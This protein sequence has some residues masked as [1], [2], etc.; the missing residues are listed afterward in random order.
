MPTASVIIAAGGLGR[1]FLAAGARAAERGPF[2]QH[3]TKA[4]VPLAGKPVLAHTLACFAEIPSVVEFIVAVPEG[5]LDWA[6][7]HFDAAGVG[8]RR[9]KIVEGGRDRPDSVAR[10]LEVSDPGTELVAVHDAVRPLIRRAVAEE[11][12]RVA[13]E[14]GAAVVGRPVDHTVKR[15]AEDRSVTET[16]H[17]H[18][19]WVAQ[20]P[21]VFRREII[22]N[23]YHKRDEVV[24]EV[25]DD[26]QL[27]EAL[28]YEV[29]MVLG[30]AVNLKITTP[31]DLRICEAILA[32]GW[33]FDRRTP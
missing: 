19:L 20:T 25:T 21:Q 8:G 29:V 3:P 9:L 18:G 14:R 24:G 11:A 31:E 10:A 16:V 33:P 6:E 15:V 4:F 27:V 23:A 32:A 7:E 12:M 2:E 22:T 13:I 17:R 5:A 26:A 28:G 30:D 1:R